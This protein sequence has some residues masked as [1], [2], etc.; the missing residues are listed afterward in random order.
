MTRESGGRSVER[1]VS[2]DSNFVEGEEKSGFIDRFVDEK[3]WIGLV[4]NWIGGTKS[5][6]SEDDIVF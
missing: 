5:G 6:E 3:S 1:V 4:D 2:F